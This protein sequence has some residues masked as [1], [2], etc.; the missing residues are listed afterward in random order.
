MEFMS[1]SAGM[2]EIMTVIMSKS[3]AMTKNE[4]IFFSK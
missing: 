2:T 4:S 1:E 3:A